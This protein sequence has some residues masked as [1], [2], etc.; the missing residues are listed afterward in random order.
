MDPLSTS[1][2]LQKRAF[3]LWVVA[4]VAGASGGNDLSHI[5]VTKL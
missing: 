2:A 1:R 5:E 4:L 3:S